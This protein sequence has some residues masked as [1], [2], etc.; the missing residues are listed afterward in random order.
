MQPARNEGKRETKSEEERGVEAK[1]LTGLAKDFA[2]RPAGVAA[3]QTAERRTQNAC[4][5][6]V[7]SEE[8]DEKAPSGSSVPTFWVAVPTRRFEPICER[9]SS[10]GSGQASEAFNSS[11]EE[12]QKLERTQGISVCSMKS[13]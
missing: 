8:P 6:N 11:R 7:E 5:H 2:A 3:D 9:A 10:A 13:R 4:Q 12:A 1:L